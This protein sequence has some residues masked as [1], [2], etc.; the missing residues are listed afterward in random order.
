LKTLVIPRSVQVIEACALAGCSALPLITFEAG[1]QLRELQRAAI[2]S[3]AIRR[4]DLP[5]SLQI[6]G[7]CCFERCGSLQAVTFETDSVLREIG[8][9]AFAGCNRLTAISIPPLVNA[10]LQDT[11]S[12]C[13]GLT[14][15]TFE[16]ELALQD[17]D[18]NAFIGARLDFVHIPAN[19]TFPAFVVIPENCQIVTPQALV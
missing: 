8:A 7:G 11:F 10:L 18:K 6:I 5:R 4:I 17:L 13:T 1:S 9:M 3:C 19:T 12:G 14:D 2:S 16:G 15:V